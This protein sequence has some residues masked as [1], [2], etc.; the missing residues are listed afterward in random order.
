MFDLADCGQTVPEDESMMLL[1]RV[2]GIVD[3]T[4]DQIIGQPQYQIRIDRVKAGRYGLR[5]DDIQ[6]V[7]EIAIGGK[8]AT[9]VIEEEKRF[10]W[11]H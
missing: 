2:H 5:S 7:I 3:L 11:R 6:K 10:N 4:C 1:D 9:Q 8:N